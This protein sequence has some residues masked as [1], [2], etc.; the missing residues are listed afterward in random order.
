MTRI[1]VSRLISSI[2]SLVGASLLAFIFLRL[3]PGDPARLIL[4]PF[5]TPTAIRNLDRQL[6]ID[7]PIYRE[8]WHY[9]FSF[10]TGSWGYSFST[11]QSVSAT[12]GARL[13][14]TIELGLYAF[15]VAFIGA[16]VLAVTSVYGRFPRLRRAIRGF[17][18]FGLGVP[19][20]WLGIVL[21]LLLSQH[22]HIF[23]GPVGRLGATVAPPPRITGLYTV[24]AVLTGHFGTFLSALWY[25]IL[26]VFVLALVPLSYLTRLL[27]AN[28]RD[29]ADEPFV[30]VVQSKGVS[31]W[32]AF[33][34]H[35]L[36]NAFLPSLTASGLMFGQL[37]AGSVLVESVFNWPGIGNLV[38]QSVEKD[39]YSIVEIFIMLAAGIYIIVNL[40][41]DV[42][43]ARLDPRTR[44]GGG[45]R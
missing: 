36:P 19:Q 43:V 23:P 1:V 33:I 15:I 2:T 40:I 24:D 38:F 39:D 7:Q 13:P 16:L 12:I 21:L 20:F 42:L 32:R 31:R 29:V 5:A 8:Y 6:G 25:L 10:F 3:A 4:G 18:F 30:L 17:G 26:P 22:L 9:L 44:A 14:A 28:L 37:L 35:V 34:R 11:G 45:P 27:S 41:V